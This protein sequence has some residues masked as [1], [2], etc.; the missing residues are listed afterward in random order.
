LEEQAAKAETTI[1]AMKA[2]SSWQLTAP[3]R[4]VGNKI[5][6]TRST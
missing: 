5:K 2:S 6:S 3:L 4:L 1:N